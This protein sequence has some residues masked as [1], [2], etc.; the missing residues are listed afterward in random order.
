M[1]A[2]VENSITGGFSETAT[3][4]ETQLLQ[5][6]NQGWELFEEAYTTIDEMRQL[7]PAELDTRLNGDVSEQGLEMLS[8]FAIN[9]E[10]TYGDTYSPNNKG[11]VEEFTYAGTDGNPGK[12]FSNIKYNGNDV[13]SFTT[14]GDTWTL[15]ADGKWSNQLGVKQDFGAVTFDKNGMV[16]AGADAASLHVP[17]RTFKNSA[18]DNYQK[19]V[20]GRVAQYSY[21]DENG[22]EVMSYSN[23]QYNENGD[24]VAFADND[25]NEW[26]RQP[27]DPTSPFEAD[28][29]GGG[30]GTSNAID[31]SSARS[32]ADL[33]DV[34]FDEN[35]I[36]GTGESSIHH[37]Y[38]PLIRATRRDA[39]VREFRSMTEK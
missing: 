7:T 17:T 25:G 29:N 16:A 34:T 38:A 14:G 3:S 10:N 22:N 5:T 2:G 8:G 9:F 20:D 37:I 31:G 36:H 23:I 32:P 39:I 18:G 1:P 26:Q 24:V 27:A 11:Q 6:L 35:G 13:N 33:G 28:R 15:G 19:N 30:W 4:D 21:C 12:T